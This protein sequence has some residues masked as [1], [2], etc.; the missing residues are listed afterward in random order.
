MLTTILVVD[1]ERDLCNT[2]GDILRDEGYEVQCAYG[3]EEA[4]ALLERADSRLPQ[5]CLVDLLMPG[6]TGEEFRQRQLANPRTAAI[7]TL[8]MSA[9]LRT[10]ATSGAVAGSYLAGF[11]A[12]DGVGWVEKPFALDRLLETIRTLVAR[13]LPSAKS[14]QASRAL[15]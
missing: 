5:L 8:L 6:M 15:D 9:M 12:D 11:P 4:L 10:R 1:D 7:P 14:R 3:A 13:A 2:L